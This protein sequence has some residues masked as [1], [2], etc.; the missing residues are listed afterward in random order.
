MITTSIA[1][2]TGLPADHQR[3]VLV[4]DPA[5]S[6]S[7][8]LVH[9][10][11]DKGFKILLATT[12]DGVRSFL[13]SRSIDFA[14][15]EVRFPD[16]CAFDLV[17]EIRAANPRS[18][19]LIHSAYCNLPVAVAAA[20][21]GATDVLPKPVETEFLLQLL[22][23]RQCDLETLAKPLPCPDAIRKEHVR[24]VYADCGW[25]IARA[26]RQLSM[27]RRTLQRMLQRTDMLVSASSRFH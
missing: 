18:R 4:A 7:C 15:L 6:H 9:Y 2:T 23:G 5:L 24:T 8:A 12:A 26:A 10:F 21:A 22:L 3:T 1:T 16:G 11:V 20:K 14:M 25:N 27:H 17:S 19:I 13:S